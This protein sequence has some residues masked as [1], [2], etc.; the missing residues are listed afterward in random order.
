MKLIFI[1]MENRAF[2]ASEGMTFVRKS[3][4]ARFGHFIYLSIIDSIDNY[5][6]E[7]MT[8]EEIKELEEFNEK[9]NK[10]ENYGQNIYITDLITQINIKFSDEIQFLEYY[11]VNGIDASKAQVIETW[12][13]D[14]INAL[15]YNKYIPEFIN[16]F[17]RYTRN[18]FVPSIDLTFLD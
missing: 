12:D 10:I 11:G 13:M 16:L 2:E 5:T 8:E 18:D 4:N 14:S 15:G 3:D 6:E 17:A 7:P 9:I 1:N